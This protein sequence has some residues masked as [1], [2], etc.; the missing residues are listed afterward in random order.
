MTLSVM[1]SA[2][3]HPGCTDDSVVLNPVSRGFESRPLELS[4]I[5]RFFLTPH[6]QNDG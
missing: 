5:P 3:K 1:L 6:R 2:A 4:L